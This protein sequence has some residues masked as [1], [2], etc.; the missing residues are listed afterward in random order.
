[1][2][3]LGPSPEKKSFFGPQNDVWVHFD[4]VFNRQ[5]TRTVTRSLGTRETKLEKQCSA[6]ITRKPTVRP[7]GVVALSPPE[8]ATV[9]HTPRQLPL[10]SVPPHI[11]HCL[12]LL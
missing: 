11:R 10:D 6:K 9:R 4:T 12:R 7:R 2:V 1:V 3:G 8:Y 5:K